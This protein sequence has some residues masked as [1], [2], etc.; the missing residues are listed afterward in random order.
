MA[1]SHDGGKPIK[2][3]IPNY[4]PPAGPK[5][6]RIGHPVTQQFRARNN[7][8]GSPRNLSTTNHGNCGSQCKSGDKD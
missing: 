3:P 6:Q 1:H 4:K 8:S 7:I 2:K 5:L